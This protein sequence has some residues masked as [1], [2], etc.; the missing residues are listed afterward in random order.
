MNNKEIVA[1]KLYA[2][3]SENLSLDEVEKLLDRKS[4][5]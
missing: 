3:V 5:V 4:V 1:Q 2:V